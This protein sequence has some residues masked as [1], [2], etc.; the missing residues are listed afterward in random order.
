MG[1]DNGTNRNSG[2][3]DKS[4]RLKMGMEVINLTDGLMEGHKLGCNWSEVEEYFKKKY[5][6]A[7]SEA[8]RR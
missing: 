1:H 2:D 7:F 4:M 3:K 5:G 6:S 8:S